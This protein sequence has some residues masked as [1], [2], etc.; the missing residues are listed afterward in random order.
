MRPVLRRI[1]RRLPQSMQRRLRPAGKKSLPAKTSVGAA[2]TLASAPSPVEVTEGL[3]AEWRLKDALDTL[4]QQVLADD[5]T[6]QTGLQLRVQILIL[7]GDLDAAREA[8]QLLAQSHPIDPEAGRLQLALGMKPDEPSREVAWQHVLATGAT[9]KSFGKAI[10]YLYRAELFDDCIEFG[11]LGIASIGRTAKTG[12]TTVMELA[13]RNWIGMALEG[14]GQYDR[15]VDI[16]GGQL[17]HPRTAV[18]AAN[19]VARC[20]LE[21]GHP[22]RSEA[23]LRTMNAHPDDPLPFSLLA[24]DVLQAQGK[25]GES[26][27]LYRTRALSTALAEFFELPSPVD[28]K[29]RTGAHKSALFL[30][31]GGPGDELRLCSIYED[32]ATLVDDVTITSDPRLAAMMERS[33]PGIRFLSTERHRMD[34]AKPIEDR[35]LI[36][37]RG[38]YHFLSDRAVEVGRTKD[39]VCSVL[40]TIAE[41]RPDKEAFLSVTPS[42]LVPD[43]DLREYWSARIGAGDGKLKV[44]LAWRSMLGSVARNR[45][46][47]QVDD[48]ARLGGLKNV[49]FWLLQPT[50]TPEEL[51]RLAEL[52]DFKIP[53]GLHLI[54]DLEGQLAF[55]SCLDVVVAPFMTTAEL[56]AAAGT[57]TAMLSVTQ[58]TLWRR[59]PDGTDIF[60]PNAHIFRLDADRHESMDAV[61]EFIRSH[62][63]SGR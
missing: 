5:P 59:R 43:G 44:G 17:A 28:L 36:N 22:A 41:V 47:L 15:A 33:F 38:L 58:S 35:T 13:F 26:Y 25:I 20:W 29:L 37:D 4:D 14:L 55:A 1:Y 32:L 8:V 6:D 23:I 30:A 3:I 24:L 57:S 60:R 56:A 18:N 51:E 21:L 52:I 63:P 19:G 49:E 12:A 46:Y 53:D 9:P 31:E 2:P 27:Q 50:P 48:L 7:L 54:D 16:Y 10:R 45:H 39:V 40:D 42:P 61:V 62:Q 11:L 34:I